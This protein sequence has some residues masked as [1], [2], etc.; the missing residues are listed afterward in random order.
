MRLPVLVG[1]AHAKVRDRLAEVAGERVCGCRR[2]LAG[3][4]RLALQ[5]ADLDADAELLDPGVRWGAL[6]DPVPPSS[7]GP[8]S[9]PGTSTAG[10]PAPAP[11]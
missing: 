9:L 8:R 3:R 5:A 1:R 4:V 7:S 11:A 2:G 10:R 6:G